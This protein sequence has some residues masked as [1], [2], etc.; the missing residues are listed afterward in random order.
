LAPESP[1]WLLASGRAEEAKRIL[2]RYHAKGKE[3]DEL[4]AV[5]Y[6]EISDMIEREKRLEKISWIS[7]LSTPGN[8]KRV[9][10][11]LI[12][13]IFS[14]WAESVIITYYFALILLEIGVKSPI[15]QSGIN[16]GLKIFKWLVARLG[17]NLADRHGRRK[18]WLLS[19]WAMLF[20]LVMITITS[21][22][23]AQY[24]RV[25]AGYSFIVFLFILNFCYGIAYPALGAMDIAETCPYS[26][27]AKGMS[28]LFAISYTA[29]FCNQYVNLIALQKIG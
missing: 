5:E 21:S 18:L 12:V 11:I 25:A 14:T 20:A 16:G 2:A 4:V 23:F 9:S 15:K 24:G 29:G 6:S 17:S 22:E 1:R 26:L 13:S 27:R 19:G 8:R 3:D 10:L 28:L 7:L